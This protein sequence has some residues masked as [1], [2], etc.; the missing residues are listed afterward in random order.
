MQI[1]D[2]LEFVLLRPYDSI[3]EVG[4]L[5]LDVGLARSNIECPV[6]NR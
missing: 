5:A 1:D 6:A 4:K 2:H 3:L